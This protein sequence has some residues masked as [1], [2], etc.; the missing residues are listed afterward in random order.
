MKIDSASP[1]Q[2]EKIAA[3]IGRN[4]HGGEIIELISDLGGGKTTFVRGL[5]R[6]ASSSS[7]VSSPTFKIRNDYQAPKF[8]IYHFDFFRLSEPGLITGELDEI[9]GD[10]KSV[11]IIEWAEIVQAVLPKERLTIKFS[12]TGE[13]TRNLEFACPKALNYLLDGLK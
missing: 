3:Q 5:A 7:Q 6:G 12:S 13:Q 8:T 9:I 2:T 11:I 1:K 4:L 10:K